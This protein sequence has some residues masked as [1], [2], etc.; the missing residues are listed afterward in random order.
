MKYTK[1]EINTDNKTEYSK[2][3]YETILKPK[4]STEKIFCSICNKSYTEWNKFK[5]IQS[6]KH[7]ALT[8]QTDE[9]VIF[10]TALEQ[11]NK[12]RMKHGLKELE[13]DKI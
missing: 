7:I 11:M 5:H 4:Y 1:R 12:L 9:D 6:Q 10:Y 3:Y 13:S 2:I 8:Q